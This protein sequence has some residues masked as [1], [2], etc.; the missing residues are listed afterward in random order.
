M[1]LNCTNFSRAAHQTYMKIEEETDSTT[2]TMGE[3]E[4]VRSEMQCMN[5]MKRKEMKE[6]PRS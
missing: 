3:M 5:T 6:I 1:K 4:E 2:T